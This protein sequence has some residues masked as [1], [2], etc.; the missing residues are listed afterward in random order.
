M[1][2]TPCAISVDF[3]HDPKNY[4]VEKIFSMCPDVYE[5]DGVKKLAHHLYPKENYA[6]HHKLFKKYLREGMIVKKVNKILFYRE[7]AW[8]KEY[9]EFCVEQQTIA[10]ERQEPY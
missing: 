5:E 1:E 3:E 4:P 2:N 7:R 9:I 8:M 6:V 10:T